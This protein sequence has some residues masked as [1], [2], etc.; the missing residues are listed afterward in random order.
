MA[1][2]GDAYENMGLG[3][4]RSSSVVMD[5][6]SSP[7]SLTWGVVGSGSPLSWGCCRICRT[8]SILWTASKCSVVSTA[9]IPTVLSITCVLKYLLSLIEGGI[10]EPP[11]GTG[12]AWM[13]GFRASRRYWPSPSEGRLHSPCRQQQAV[14]CH[15]FSTLVLWVLLISLLPSYLEVHFYI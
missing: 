2:V 3:T 10:S 6:C 1:S 4:L 12:S 13:E 11:G 15:C 5:A 8:L 7:P 14:W 9:F